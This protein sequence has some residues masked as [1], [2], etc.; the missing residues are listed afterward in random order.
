MSHLNVFI[1]IFIILAGS[2]GC[3]ELKKTKTMEQIKIMRL[4]L[5]LHLNQLVIVLT[6]M[7]SQE[8]ILWETN[9][10]IGW[11]SISFHLKS[12]SSN[13]ISVI[14]RKVRDWTGAGLTVLKL[15]P[16]GVH[17][18]KINLKDGWW[19]IDEA[20][21]NLNNETILIQ[22]VFESAPSSEAKENG[23]FVGTVYSNWVVSKPP[24]DWL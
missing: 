23:V 5:D 1:G 12:Q 4:D 14:K 22:A 7:S 6:N 15:P 19:D 8:I 24:H 20:K 10:Q 2:P 18:L 3:Q 17:T 11:E 16:G 13:A 9:N 21:N